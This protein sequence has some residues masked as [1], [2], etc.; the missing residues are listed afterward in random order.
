MRRAER[1]HLPSAAISHPGRSGKNNEDRFAVSAF[2]TGAK[3]GTPVLLAVLADGI[4]GHRAGEVAA[5]MAV[6][7]ISS[8]VE[9]GQIDQPLRLLAQAVQTTS[10]EIR[11]VSQADAARAGMGA[12]CAAALV[13]GRKLY[14]VTAGDS[15]IYLIRDGMIHQIST[16]HTWVQEALELGEIEPEEAVSHPNA[17]VIRRYLGSPEPPTPDFRI[18][19]TG[20]ESDAEAE[21]NQGADL[22]TGDQLLLCSDGLTDLVYD[23]EILEA[24]QRQPSL[25]AACEALVELANQRGGHDN[26][27]LI[28]F[29]VPTRSNA[30]AP[31]RW[32]YLA[33]GC[34]GLIVAVGLIT[35]LALGWNWL[36]GGGTETATPTS[37][38]AQIFATHTLPAVIET[39]VIS[40]PA[41]TLP[42]IQLPTLTDTPLP[43]FET[44]A[45][46]LTPWPTNTLEPIG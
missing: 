9:F 2:R 7:R 26:I 32:P 36:T 22:V 40:P 24:F 37:T 21:Q 12:T 16:D 20:V 1:A 43:V 5:E 19:L 44:P 46:T 8:F 31:L 33:L 4:G 45:P 38:P 11:H 14:T 15:R 17:H 10:E 3:N 28:A 6:E 13:I 39:A 34:I 42:P 25:Q 27:T 41:E 35:G 23:D 30:A 29:D 18:R